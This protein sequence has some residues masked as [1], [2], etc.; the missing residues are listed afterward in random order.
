MAINKEA[1]VVKKDIL[2]TLVKC[3]AMPDAFKV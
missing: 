3:C 2:M 1:P